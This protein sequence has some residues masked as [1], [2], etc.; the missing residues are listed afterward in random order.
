MKSRSGK[1]IIVDDIFDFHCFNNEKYEGFKL[2]WDSN[3][4]FGEMTF[5]KTKGKETWEVFPP[6]CPEGRSRTVRQ[7][8]L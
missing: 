2:N 8:D 5:S 1:E 4:G 6:V 3:I 7:I